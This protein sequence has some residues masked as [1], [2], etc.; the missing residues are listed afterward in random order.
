MDPDSIINHEEQ[1]VLATSNSSKLSSLPE[2]LRVLEPLA[3]NLYWVW[4]RKI[5]RIFEEIDLAAW[6]GLGHNPVLF[7]QRIGKTRLDEL[8]SKDDFLSRLENAYT[9]QREYLH[10]KEN[11]WYHKTFGLLGRSELVAYFSAEFGLTECLRTYSGGLGILSGDHLKSASDLGIPLIGVGLFYK[12]GYFSQGVNDEGWQVESYP[13]NNPVEL[14]VEPVMDR[15][16]NEP[17]IVSVP[18]E[19][20]QVRVRAWRV[21]V[22]RVTLLLLDTNLPGLNSKQ[23]CEITAELYGGDVENRIKQEMILGFGGTKVIRALALQPSVYH[24]NEGHAAFAILERIREI[25]E[26]DKP[27]TGFADAAKYSRKANLF[28]THTPVSA[29]IDVFDR[30]LVEKY[31]G[32][33]CKKIGITIDELLKVGQEYPGSNGFNMA[34]FA[35]R[36]SSYV[37]A[38]SKLHRRVASKL[39]RH[40][41]EEG[42]FDEITSVTNGIHTLSWTSNSFADL[43]DEFLGPSWKE[44]TSNGEV[45]SKVREIPDDLLWQTHLKEKARLIEY[46][47]TN[48]SF[49]HYQVSSPQDILDPK[50]LTI[51]FARRFATYKRATLI[52]REREALLKLLGNKERPIQFVFAGKAHPRDHEAKKLIQEILTFAKTREAN[53][54]I[55]FLPDYDIT[56]AR[57]MVQG[58]D[59]WLN[60]PQR[61]LEACGTSG[62]KTL[63]NGALNFSIADG[64]W[65]EAHSSDLGWTITP[66]E[67]FEDPARQAHADAEALF[68][69]LENDILPEFYDRKSD[70]DVP[71]RWVQK[72]K[73]SISTLTPRFTTRGMVKEYA[74]RFYFKNNKKTVEML[75]K[76][77]LGAEI[78]DSAAVS[79]NTN[80]W[81]K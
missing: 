39:W 59:L 8:A 52:L 53:G 1:G 58:V 29:G 23:D 44:D 6:D 55:V 74:E 4:N 70:D 73:N 49:S 48:F 35:I 66:L 62:M 40:V 47:R 31:L 54:R 20:R 61:P 14:P 25:M 42:E 17:L 22:G 43:Y 10:G 9:I 30:G 2:R 41:I 27:G 45:W 51:G 68:A 34:V 26:E 16:S 78:L 46:I 3:S 21:A 24:L 81:D 28:T 79:T 75:N 37:N 77:E 60:N 32:S 71:L 18:I 57:H 12:C 5:R 15:S 65:D 38:V 80:N 50:A 11:T 33:F 63:P 69:T 64:W 36:M 67:F 19:D 13:E 56:V 72:M 76:S 7:L